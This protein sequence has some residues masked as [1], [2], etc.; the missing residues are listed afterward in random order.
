MNL[1]E[2]FLFYY[3]FQHVGDISLYSYQLRQL[4]FWW[5]HVLVMCTWIWFRD[6]ISFWFQ[7]SVLGDTGRRDRMKRINRF[8]SVLFFPVVIAGTAVAQD[9][10]IYPAKGQS[11]DQ[12]DAHLLKQAHVA[13]VQP[14][15]PYVIPTSDRS[16]ISIER[17]RWDQLH[18]QYSSFWYCWPVS[19]H[20]AREFELARMVKSP[21][22][23]SAFPSHFTTKILDSPRAMCTVLWVIPRSR[24]AFWQR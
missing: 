4:S 2:K 22:R 9:L 14:V 8:I 10:M 15:N 17:G 23:R 24:R 21:N 7:L 13:Q 18:S 5:G 3:V 1:Q 11:Q 6:L 19:H 16:S 20:S 12:M